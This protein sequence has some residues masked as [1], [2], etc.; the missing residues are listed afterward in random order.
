MSTSDFIGSRH[1]VAHGRKAHLA[2]SLL[3]GMGVMMFCGV[4]LDQ[5]RPAL[6]RDKNCKSCVRE[7]NRFNAQPKKGARP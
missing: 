3:P 2:L 7:F 1:V 4:V 5:S 6:S